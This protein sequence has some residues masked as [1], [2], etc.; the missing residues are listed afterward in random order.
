MERQL[1]RFACDT[2][3][4]F[5]VQGYDEGE[6]L[7]IAVAH[8]KSGHPGVEASEEKLKGILEIVPPTA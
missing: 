6:I 4:G 7:K 3:C 1:K 8:V 5:S 2:V